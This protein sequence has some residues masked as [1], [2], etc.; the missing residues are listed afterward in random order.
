MRLLTKKFAHQSQ[1]PTVK[2][3]HII[4][5]IKLTNLLKS[6][7]LLQKRKKKLPDESKPFRVS[8]KLNG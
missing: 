8:L 6:K 2:N 1:I 5:L 7:F 3:A 4:V